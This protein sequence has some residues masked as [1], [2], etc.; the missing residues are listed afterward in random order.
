MTLTPPLF[1]WLHSNECLFDHQWFSN[2]ITDKWSKYTVSGGRVIT[3]E[4]I[5]ER[6]KLHLSHKYFQK[7][8]H[9][10]YAYRIMTESGAIIEWK[11]DDWETGAWQCILRELQRINAVNIIVVVTRY[12]GWVHLHWDR[13]RHVV[14][15]TKIFLEKSGVE[16][17]PS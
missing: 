15:A 7:A 3:K 11:N 4:D 12:F 9:N 13:F 1:P 6:C 14:D 17:K 10:T 5:K 8:T 16:K 2:I